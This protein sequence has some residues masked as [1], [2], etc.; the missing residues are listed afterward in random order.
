M[1]STF[2]LLASFMFCGFVFADEVRVQYLIT[3]KTEFGE[4]NDALYFTLDEYSA[5]DPSVVAEQRKSRV[6][7]YV[8]AVKDS[9]VAEPEVVEEIQEME[10]Q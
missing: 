9:Q 7:G 2:F 5:V 3:E 4:F 1:K 10:I 6:D 8:N